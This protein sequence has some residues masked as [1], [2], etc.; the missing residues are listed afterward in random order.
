[1]TPHQ[2]YNRL[3]KDRSYLPKWSA[4]PAPQRKKIKARLTQAEKIKQRAERELARLEQGNNW[5][6]GEIY[7]ETKEK[8]DAS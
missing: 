6:A 7:C 2:F 3:R 1:M 4:L 8:T 5:L